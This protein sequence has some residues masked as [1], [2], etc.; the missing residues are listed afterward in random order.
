MRAARGFFGRPLLPFLVQLAVLAPLI[1][2]PEP[3]RV[4]AGYLFWCRGCCRCSR[5]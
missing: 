1:L 4:A 2:A 5:S 3:R